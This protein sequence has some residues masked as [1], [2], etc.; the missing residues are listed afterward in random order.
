MWP[1]NRFLEHFVVVGTLGVVD[2][3][4]TMHRFGEAADPKVVIRL[5]DKT[6]YR[7]L[8]LRPML[9]VGEA[10][11]DG[12]LE[13]AEGTL[14][15]FLELAGRNL[16]AGR[17][18]SD[19]AFLR[20]VVRLLQN[21]TQF[22][23]RHRSRRNAAHH[24]DLSGRLYDTFLDESRQYSCA[25]FKNPEA[26]LEEAQAAKARHIAA[27]L[28]LQKDQKVLD[29]GCGWGRFDLDLARRYGVAVDGITLSQEQLASAVAAKEKSESAARVNF[30]LKDYREMTGSYDRIVS[31]GMFEHVGV[32]FYAAFFRKIAELLSA[33]GVA[34][35]HTIASAH[36][37]GLGNPWISK[38]IFPGGYIPSLSEIAPALEGAGLVVTDIESLRLHYARTLRLWRE[39]FLANWNTIQDLYDDRFRRMWE[40]YLAGCE[41]AFRFGGILVYQIQ[42]AKDQTAVP[43]TRDYIAAAETAG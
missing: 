16:A 42:L 30:S 13:M 7:K 20:F 37:P 3:D 31:I 21:V 41:M 26:G 25:Y 12:T 33:R 32:P 28:L 40:F 24:Y 6:L 2:A 35:I 34:L 43:L 18:K 5:K 29:I 19:G 15:D 36:G 39:R 23:S 8:A 11:M 38:Y 14:W 10:Y 22:N 1:L 9:C 4:G 17:G 27:K